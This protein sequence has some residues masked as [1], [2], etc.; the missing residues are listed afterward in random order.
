MSRVR[1]LARPEVRTSRASSYDGSVREARPMVDLIGNQPGV[2]VGRARGRPPP[3]G[4]IRHE[5]G[6]ADLIV[7]HRQGRPEVRPGSDA[8]VVLHRHHVRE[9]ARQC[10]GRTRRAH[11]RRR[12]RGGRPGRN[13]QKR[14]RED[15][16][17]SEAKSFHDSTSAHLD[18]PGPSRNCQTSC[19]TSAWPRAPS[20]T[21]SWA[22]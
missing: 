12:R 4:G 13:Q 17:T 6:H 2:T 5:F 18:Q 14:C 8:A 21:R 10:G 15:D 22:P 3:E 16:G 7:R 19:A 11:G 9:V 20:P 1:D